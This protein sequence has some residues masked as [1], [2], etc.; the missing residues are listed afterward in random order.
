MFV[1]KKEI[2]PRNHKR[3][4]NLIHKLRTSGIDK[5]RFVP[6]N[7]EYNTV[8]V[9]NEI[10]NDEGLQLH[11]ISIK[12][13]PNTFK[14]EIN[15]QL[16]QFIDKITT[17]FK[18]IEKNKNIKAIKQAFIDNEKKLTREKNIPEDDDLEIISG[19]VRHAHDGRKKIVSEDEHFWG[20]AE[21]ILNNFDIEVIREREC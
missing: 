11:R 3:L 13:L 8:K 15:D 6:G 9:M 4:S 20:Y 5:Y 2:L 17:E 7:L 1:G 12:N 16:E 18:E 19:Y 10:I 14:S 21:L